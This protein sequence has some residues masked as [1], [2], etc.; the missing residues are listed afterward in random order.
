MY[1]L[2]LSTLMAF[3]ITTTTASNSIWS[4]EGTDL[5][6]PRSSHPYTPSACGVWGRGGGGGGGNGGPA[7][8]CIHHALL[9][10]DMLLAAKHDNL[11]EHFLYGVAGGSSDGECGKCY[12]IRL[13]DAEKVWRD[14]FPQL[15]IQ[16]VN[17]GYDV[18]AGQFDVMVGAGGQG[19]FTAVNVDCGTHYCQGGPCA[20]GMFGGDF[21][22]WTDAEFPDPNKCYSGG[23]KYFEDAG[24]DVLEKKCKKLSGGSQAL[25]D[26]ILWDSCIRSNRAYLHQNFYGTEYLRVRCPESLYRLTGLRRIDDNNLP[27][28]HIEQQLPLTCGGSREQGHTCITTMHDGCVPSCAWPGKVEADPAYSRVDRCDYDNTVL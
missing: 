12:Q 27:D 13:L 25:K 21:E 17:S 3:V 22:A 24:A 28:P 8:A 14:D 26:R 9:S 16:I 1:Y 2:S 10:D 6:S 5:P 19:Y 4:W 7:F 23:I 11:S 20:M 18:M 15:L